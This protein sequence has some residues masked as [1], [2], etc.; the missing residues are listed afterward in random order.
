MNKIKDLIFLVFFGFLIIQNFLVMINILFSP[1]WMEKI[2]WLT[3]PSGEDKKLRK[4]LYCLFAML[5]FTILFYLK[6]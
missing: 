4:T 3:F 5:L 2:E 1:K 6:L